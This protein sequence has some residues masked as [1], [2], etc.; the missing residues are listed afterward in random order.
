MKK[1][2]R[3][4]QKSAP[5]WLC[6]ASVLIVNSAASMIWI[7]SRWPSAALFSFLHLSMWK[8]APGL[9]CH[10]HA[11]GCLAV[12]LLPE[13]ESSSCS[14][15]EWITKLLKPSPPARALCL[16]W[17]ILD[18]HGGWFFFFFKAFWGDFE[19]VRELAR[20]HLWLHCS[21][22]CLPSVRWFSPCSLLVMC[23]E[24]CQGGLRACPS[25]WAAR[26]KP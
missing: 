19:I 10:C 2:P 20:W 14:F 6:S 25:V 23:N 26:W 15:Q 3:Q 18:V 8:N 12:V 9:P 13:P 5:E 24:S 7:S 4:K 11:A 17:E 21:F 16:R 1:I 22:F